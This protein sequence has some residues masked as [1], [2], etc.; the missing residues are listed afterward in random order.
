MKWQAELPC[1]ILILKT[2]RIWVDTACLKKF[3]PQLELI[4]FGLS[5]LDVCM[6]VK[7]KHTDLWLYASHWKWRQKASTVSYISLYVKK[8]TLYVH[9]T[10][11]FL[12]S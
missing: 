2:I 7:C 3:Y 1:S 4:W 6:F 9:T 12:S 11:D 8:H 5:A 10:Y